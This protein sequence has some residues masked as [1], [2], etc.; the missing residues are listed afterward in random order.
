MGVGK[1]S[2]G[3]LASLSCARALSLALL[4]VVFFFARPLREAVLSERP[5]L[6]RFRS[7][8]GPSQGVKTLRDCNKGID[9]MCVC[10]G[11]AGR[12]PN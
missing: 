10:F 2:G 9:T 3:F 5:N 6:D 12:G 8:P 11:V 4:S 7:T 1:T